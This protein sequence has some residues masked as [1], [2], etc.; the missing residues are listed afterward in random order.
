M[1]KTL[2]QITQQILSDMNG[3]D[4]NSIFDTEEAEQ[5]A[6]IVVATYE[7]MMSNSN[8][9][10]TRRVMTLT[11][12]SD[13]AR[14]THFHIPSEIKEVG[15]INYDAS[16]PGALRKQFR[17]VLY[18]DPDD[19]LR[20]LNT[21]DNTA[22]NVQVV[23]DPSGIELSIINN[24]QPMHYTSFDDNVIVMDAFDSDKESTLQPSNMQVVAYVVPDFPLTDDSIP[25]LPISTYSMLIEEATSRAQWKLREFQDVKSEIEAGRQRRWAARK[26]WKVDRRTRY[27]NYGR[28]V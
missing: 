7:A 6:R 5:V 11:S 1:S 16:K 21:R 2:L 13:N 28:R 27:P 24:H 18:L 9:A 15:S 3:D 4:V 22:P 20:R 17:P 14:P 25:D 26:N 8:W 23:T 10:N 12:F 19:F